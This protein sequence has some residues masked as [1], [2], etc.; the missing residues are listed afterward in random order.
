MDLVLR[1]RNG[2]SLQVSCLH[3]LV[4]PLAQGQGLHVT[5]ISWNATGSVLAC[6]YGR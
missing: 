3:T 5:G 4:Y 2:L 6:A 1:A